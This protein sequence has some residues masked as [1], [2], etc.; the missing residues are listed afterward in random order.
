VSALLLRA[1]RSRCAVVAVAGALALAAVTAQ[2][3]STTTEVKSFEI[4]SVDGNVLVVKGAEGTRE[5]TVPSDFRF[6]VGDKQVTVQDLKPGMKGK[7]TIT[8]T[9]TVKP[10]FVTEVK[11]GVVVKNLGAGS[12]IIRSAD[13]IKMFSQGEIN[14]RGIR[15][16]RA[17]QPVQLYDLRENDKLSATIVTEGPPQVLTEREVQA[18]I[19]TMAAAPAAPPASSAGSA[20]P[21]TTAAAPAGAPA[22]PAAAPA[23][24]PA[25]APAAAPTAARAAP[26]AAPA[27]TETAGGGTS[28]LIWGA[29]IV[30][31]LVGAYF[32]FGRSGD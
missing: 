2:A 31:V 15:I 18:T 25:A 5:L 27:S 16:Y 3:Q 6:T 22:A 7:A 29:L 17:G 30:L 19:A 23:D 13:S 8:T 11:N 21:A 12:V 1:H 24:A 10:V 4:I 20:A 14:K 9:T 26:P 28:W 32:L